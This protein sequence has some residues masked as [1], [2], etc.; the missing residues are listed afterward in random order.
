MEDSFDWGGIQIL[1]QVENGRIADCGIESDAMD[2]EAVLYIAAAFKG[3]LYEKQTLLCR[4]DSLFRGQTGQDDPDN[5][6]RRK[7]TSDIRGMLETELN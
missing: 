6:E 7:M 5:M 1:F 2:Q 4:I 3:C